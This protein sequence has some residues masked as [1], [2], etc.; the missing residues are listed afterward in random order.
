MIRKLLIAN[1]GE[2]ACRIIRTCRRLGVQTVAV[3]S[4]ADRDAQHVLMADESCWIGAAPAGESYLRGERLIEAALRQGAEAVH[5]GY[6]FLSENTVFARQCQQAG[7]I[8]V[9]PT[10]EAIEQMGTK[11]QAKRLMEAAGVPVVPGYHGPEQA[12]EF[13][14]AEAQRIGFPVL[15]KAV[16]GGGGKGMRVVHRPEEFAHAL[17]G[18]QQESRN[19]FGDDRVLL[20]RFVQNPRHIEVQVFGD[21][22]GNVVHCFERE[23][24]LQRRHQKILEEAPSPSIGDATREAITT[25]AV[26]AARAVGYVNAGTV[27]FIMDASEQFFFMEMNTRL[28]VEHPVT[29]AILGQ[30][31]VEW[32]LRVASGA[33]LPVTQE[34]VQRCGHAIEV[35]V[36]AEQPE[37]GFLPSTGTLEHLEF[38]VNLPGVRVDSGVVA[39]DVISVYYDPMI[40]KLIV[41][42]ADRPEALERLQQALSRSVASGLHTN[43]GFLQ[44]LTRHP[45]VVSAE[46]DTLFV[47]QRLEEL[48]SPTE[49]PE[50][51]FWAAA[52]QVL[53]SWSP[54]PSASPWER[55]DNWRLSGSLPHRLRFRTAHGERSLQVSL[56]EKESASGEARL[57]RLWFGDP[58]QAQEVRAL[59]QNPWELSWN[60]GSWSGKVFREGDTLWVIPRSGAGYGG[61]FRL[62]WLSPW[63]EADVA[64]EEGMRLTAPMPGSITRVW[65]GVG[66]AVKRGEPLVTMEAMK[67]EHTLV[68]PEDSVV[69][70]IH[71]T[72]GMLVP[73][74]AQ[75]VTLSTVAE[76]APES[77][78]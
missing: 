70:S 56:S 21:S 67:M 39:G 40:A 2:I 28:Q 75:L 15:I 76:Q 29:E 30:D 59:S 37:S 8:F 61:R 54:E 27:E 6:G 48:L 32:Q 45:A 46:A 51:V 74:E 34:Q 1:R 26:Q 35:R 55:L 49:P 14:Q 44:S 22:H 36:Y 38:P 78:S 25:A 68:A 13:L 4:D 9:G 50:P 33:P 19:A 63:G 12:L 18:A 31:L 11:D 73:A 43:L 23:C 71:Y 66:D 3:Y 62:E 17:R 7:L 24:S 5:P 72:E 65:V 60:A 20:E 47:D 16:S 10:P 53:R 52:A 42:G 69:E 41:Q 57:S 58:S 64:E 77:T